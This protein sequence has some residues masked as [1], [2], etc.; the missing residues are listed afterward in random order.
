MC[1]VLNANKKC[2][3]ETAAFH[4]CVAHGKRVYEMPAK[5][6]P[7]RTLIN[8]GFGLCLWGGRFGQV[9]WCLYF[10]H[11]GVG[12]LNG[13]QKCVEPLKNTYISIMFNRV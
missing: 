8:R 13:L 2:I 12:I 1:I 6:A 3:R 5:V 11:T 9:N 7:F 4:K 10:M